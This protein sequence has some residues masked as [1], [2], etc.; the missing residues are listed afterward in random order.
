MNVVFTGGGTGGSVTSLLAIISELKKRDPSM[1]T[2]FIGS[3]NGPERDLIEQESGITFRE[4]SAGKLRRYFSLRNITDLFAIIGGLFQAYFLLRKIKPDV[5]VGTG[6]FVSVPVMWAGFLLRIPSLAH[7]L[8]LELGLANKLVLPVVRRI[9]V[10]FQDTQLRMSNKKAV[11]TGNPFRPEIL[12]GD[13]NEAR[14]LFELHERLPVI[15][16]MGGGTGALRLNQLIASAALKLLDRFQILHLTGKG[17]GGF[18]VPHPNYHTYEFLTT[19]MPHAY[20]VADIVI[21]RAGLSTLTELSVLGKASIIVPIPHS[22]QEKNAEYFKIHKAIKVLPE[23]SLHAGRL[24]AEVEQLM[25]DADQ[26]SELSLHMRHL[27]HPEATQ[28]I[29]NEIV[30]IV[31]KKL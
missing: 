25:S 12:E 26:R 24:L 30:E 17:K 1:Q 28:K 9:T 27:A 22:H 13:V 21:S 20:A 11:L 23:R 10:G 8:D 16:V 5:I 15:V 31:T 18:T 4:I 29:A 19:E 14:A 6:S 2:T 3:K 7:Q